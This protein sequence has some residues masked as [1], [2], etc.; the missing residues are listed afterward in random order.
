MKNLPTSV[1]QGQTSP[2]LSLTHRLIEQ[3]WGSREFPKVGCIKKLPPSEVAQQFRPDSHRDR[4]SVRH[5]LPSASYCIHRSV[6]AATQKAPE[7][8]HETGF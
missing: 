1:I 3:I 5:I 4:I 8:I 7:S 2:V 6:Y